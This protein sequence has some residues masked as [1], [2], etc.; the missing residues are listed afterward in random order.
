MRSRT[1]WVVERLADLAAREVLPRGRYRQRCVW[2][3]VESE[4]CCRVVVADSVGHDYS[5]L[6]RWQ[7]MYFSNN[8]ASQKNVC[9][10]TYTYVFPSDLTITLCHNLKIPSFSWFS[11]HVIVLFYRNSCGTAKKV[12]IYCFCCIIMRSYAVSSSND[13]NFDFFSCSKFPNKKLIDHFENADLIVIWS[14]HSDPVV[15]FC[16]QP[17][18]F[19]YGD[20]NMKKIT[21]MWF[22]FIKSYFWAWKRYRIVSIV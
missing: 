13:L 6:A 12:F 4:S 8:T 9:A 19:Y 14:V 16:Y 2:L 17:P 15:Y 21:K 22:F 3:A 5:R 10:V 7:F 20:K 1:T 18:L 11:Q